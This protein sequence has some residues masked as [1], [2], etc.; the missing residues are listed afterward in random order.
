[1]IPI[2]SLCLSCSQTPRSRLGNSCQALVFPG[3]CTLA[4]S[5]ARTE[6][7]TSSGGKGEVV[8]REAVRLYGTGALTRRGFP[9]QERMVV[10]S[11]GRRNASRGAG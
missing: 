2:T 5:H 10:S 7:V 1:M 6:T 9:P 3:R 4:R 8:M 11:R